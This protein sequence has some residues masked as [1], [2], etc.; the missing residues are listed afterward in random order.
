VLFGSLLSLYALQPVVG[1]GTFPPAAVVRVLCTVGGMDVDAINDVAAT[2]L[3]RK[4]DKWEG[5]SE[6]DVSRLLR[7]SGKAIDVMQLVRIRRALVEAGAVRRPQVCSATGCAMQR[8]RCMGAGPST[9]VGSFC[10]VSCLFVVCSLQLPSRL[11][12]VDV[13]LAPGKGCRSSVGRF[14]VAVPGWLP[15]D[16]TAIAVSFFDGLTHASLAKDLRALEK[17]SSKRWTDL[18]LSDP[19]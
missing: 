19:I 1:Q 3:A 17:L 7:S 2:L 8:A 15:G 12:K 18:I 14:G 13:V 9:H 6:V 11:P 5:L 10:A 4:E 16:G